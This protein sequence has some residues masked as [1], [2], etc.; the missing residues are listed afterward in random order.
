MPNETFE[1]AMNS[2]TTACSVYGEPWPPYASGPES[3]YQPASKSFAQAALKPVGVLTLPSTSCAPSRSALALIGPVT[4]LAKRS[5][6]VRTMSTSSLPQA[7]K[8]A[9][10][11][12]SWNLRCSNRTNLISR[13]WALKRFCTLDMGDLGGSE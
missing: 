6:S 13:S 8:G 7:A 11:R 1:P 5:V 12:M 9:V 4:S 2:S 10:P 3:V